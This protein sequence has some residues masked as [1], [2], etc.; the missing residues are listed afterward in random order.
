[1]ITYKR[2]NRECNCNDTVIISLYV[3]R[4]TL[5]QTLLHQLFYSQHIQKRLKVPLINYHK[6]TWENLYFYRKQKHLSTASFGFSRLKHLFFR[7]IDNHL[8]NNQKML[9]KKYIKPYHMLD[10]LRIPAIWEIRSCNNTKSNSSYCLIF[11]W[12]KSIHWSLC[13]CTLSRRIYIKEIISKVNPLN[14]TTSAF[15]WVN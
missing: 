5:F 15:Y 8:R 11:D 2:G 4:F 9:Y 14:R 6:R 3:T 10:I 12:N 13:K 7:L 1:M